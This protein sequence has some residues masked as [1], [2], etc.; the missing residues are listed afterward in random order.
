MSAFWDAS[1]VVPLCIDQPG[2][3]EAV[4]LLEAGSPV[5]WWA[6]A[7]EATSGIVRSRLSDPQ[8]LAAGLERLRSLREEWREI[9]PSE[10]VREI[11]L[12]NLR[13]FDLRS[14]D[15]MQLAAALV[16]AEERPAGHRF[17]CN[18]RRLSDA[19]RSLG[20]DVVSFY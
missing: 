11:A 2:A 14:A 5:V 13:R 12:D 9:E 17:V 10:R 6:T 8:I 1:A 4:R 16:W 19:A 3:S 7:V 20:F 15:A 18:D